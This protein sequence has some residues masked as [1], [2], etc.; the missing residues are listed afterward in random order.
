MEEQRAVT[1]NISCNIGNIS[2]VSEQ[3]AMGSKE[4]TVANEA[5]ARLAVDLQD[6]VGRFRI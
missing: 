2:R 4:S 1:E 3:I 6:V 5:L